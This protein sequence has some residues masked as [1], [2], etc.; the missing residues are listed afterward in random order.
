MAEQTLERQ[1]PTRVERTQSRAATRRVRP[2]LILLYAVLILIGLFFVLPLV[3]MFSTS[4]KEGAEVYSDQG[5]IPANPSLANF[6]SIFSSD[7]PVIRWFTTTILVSTI[8]TML[9]LAVASL[10]GYA[11]ARMDFPGKRVLFTLLITTLLLPAVMFLVPQFLVVL[12]LGNIIP[13]LGL[14]SLPA[15]M[16][17]HLAGVFGVFFM[18]Q[19][20]LGIPTEIEEA[21]YVDG[22]SR[23]TTFTRIVLPLAGPALATLGVISF[24]ALWNDYLWPLVNCTFD[25]DGCTLQ[26]GLAYFQGQQI[27][28][29]GLMMA[30]TVIASVPVLVF[31]VFAQRWIIQSV[32]SSGV[33]G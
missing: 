29:Y 25:N 27:A 9:I 18:R 13:G 16:L 17:P 15:Y 26:A 21:A 20:F 30:G 23:L 12:R 22:A 28:E 5:W 19:F 14:A 6:E 7:F 8:G 4:L 24:L 3:W 31:Y 2:E 10:S 33:K 1:V 11:F 32:A